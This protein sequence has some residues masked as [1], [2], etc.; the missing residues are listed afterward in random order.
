MKFVPPKGLSG[1]VFSKVGPADGPPKGTWLSGPIR[2]NLDATSV[3]LGHR[4][5]GEVVAPGTHGHLVHP[6]VRVLRAGLGEPILLV[7]KVAGHLHPELPDPRHRETFAAEAPTERPELAVTVGGDL[8]PLKAF[9]PEPRVEGCMLCPLPL[10]ILLVLRHRS[11]DCRS[12]LVREGHDGNTE[13]TSAERGRP[14][15]HSGRGSSKA[16]AEDCGD[17]PIPTAMQHNTS[18]WRSFTSHNDL[19]EPVPW[20]ALAN[21][22]LRRKAKVSRVTK[23]TQFPRKAAECPK[24]APGHVRVFESARLLLEMS[25]DTGL[26][27]KAPN[28]GR[29]RPTSY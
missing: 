10:R 27:C 18:E 9:H 24:S 25:E 5:Q 13:E 28:V 14:D 26:P 15:G 4:H 12:D 6:G 17:I 2:P 3:D 22:N 29:F 21:R 1:T 7:A 23:A 20:Q 19:A 16:F 8:V 11:S